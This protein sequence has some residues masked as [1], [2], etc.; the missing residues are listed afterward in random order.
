M[1]T[2]ALLA[3]AAASHGR[4]ADRRFGDG[5]APLVVEEGAEACPAW[6][7]YG[8]PPMTAARLRHRPTTVRATTV[9]Y[10]LY[11]GRYYGAYGRPMYGGY[12][13]AYY[14]GTA[15]TARLITAGT[16]TPITATAIHGRYRCCGKLR[17]RA[18]S[19]GGAPARSIGSQV[20]SGGTRSLR[21]SPW[22]RPHDRRTDRRGARR[23][24]RQPGSQGQL[25]TI[26]PI[27]GQRT[28]REANPG[29]LR[30]GPQ[31]RIFAAL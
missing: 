19:S 26:S 22:R 16:T 27:N 30:Y 29:P 10:A 1:I 24:R 11:G 31:V 20:A 21:L 12:A 9:R 2:K 14:G 17:P 25:L 13:Y 4:H 23:G 3:L 28:G 7:G 5:P 6:R 18:R 15:P 8:M